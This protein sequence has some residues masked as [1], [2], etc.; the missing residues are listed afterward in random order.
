MAEI[1]GLSDSAEAIAPE[2]RV[3]ITVRP[4]GPFRVEG[5][6]QLVD[7]GQAGDLALPVRVVVES[8]VLRRDAR[9]RGVEVRCDPDS[10]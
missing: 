4:N 5:S 6:I 10:G 8:S 7:D 1:L 3:K 9:A 2:P